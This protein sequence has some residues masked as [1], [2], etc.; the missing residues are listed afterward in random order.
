MYTHVAEAFVPVPH[1]ERVAEIICALSRD[2]CGSINE[3]GIERL[4]DFG[5]ARAILR[6]T[7]E[8]LHFQVEAQDLITFFGIRVLLQGSLSAITTVPR[9]TLEWHPAGGA[10]FRAT[11]GESAPVAT[12]AHRDIT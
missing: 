5:D 10:P 2:Y 3:A 1:A 9:D 7:D 8:G 4:L 11:T 6:P 12:L